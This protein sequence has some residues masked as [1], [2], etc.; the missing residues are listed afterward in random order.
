M[1][2]ILLC[3]WCAGISALTIFKETSR[4][5]QFWVLNNPGRQLRMVAW[6][7]STFLPVFLRSLNIAI[8]IRIPSKKIVVDEGDFQ[9]DGVRDSKSNSPCTQFPHEDQNFFMVRVRA[10]LFHNGSVSRT[11]IGCELSPNLYNNKSWQKW[12]YLCFT[13]LRVDIGT[14]GRAQSFWTTFW[15]CCWASPL[16]MY[17]FCKWVF[18]SMPWICFD[19]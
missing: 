14:T 19:F 10:D 15:R 11:I 12:V 16:L 7:C 1:I 2:W 8:G 18:R 3:Y 6:M 17:L 9:E 4:S 5:L 13:H